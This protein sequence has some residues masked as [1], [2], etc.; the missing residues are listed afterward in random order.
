MGLD[1]NKAIVYRT[2]VG[3]VTSI[4]ALIVVAGSVEGVLV[5]VAV[6]ESRDNQ[7]LPSDFHTQKQPTVGCF[8]VCARRSSTICG[9]CAFSRLECLPLQRSSHLVF[10][11]TCL[12]EV[13]LFT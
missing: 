4:R 11:Y 1:N 2:D 7:S 6:L 5:V 3:A 12:E 13:L 8:C 10:R 9:Q